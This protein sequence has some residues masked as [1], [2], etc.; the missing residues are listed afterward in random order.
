MTTSE[1]GV[2][3]LQNIPA[4]ERY[5]EKACSSLSSGQNL[6]REAASYDCVTWPNTQTVD[7]VKQF[8]SGLDLVEL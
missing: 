7:K 1:K 6:S 3:A 4:S 8:V 5:P 2:S